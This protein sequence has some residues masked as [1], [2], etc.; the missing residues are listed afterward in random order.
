MRG[1]EMLAHLMQR[2]YQGGKER[3]PAAG[4]ANSLPPFYALSDTRARPKTRHAGCVK[5]T[6]Q[7][8]RNDNERIEAPTVIDHRSQP[9]KMPDAASWNRMA[10]PNRAAAIILTCAKKMRAWRAGM[11]GETWIAC[12]NRVERHERRPPTSVRRSAAA[13]IIPVIVS[14]KAHE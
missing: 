12:N 4:K 5:R 10:R 6:R 13:A 1:E 2:C 14:R 3:Q 11:V 7:C 8:Q 9:L